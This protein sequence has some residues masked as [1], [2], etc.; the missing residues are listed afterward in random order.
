MAARAL[1]R[2]RGEVYW[3]GTFCDFGFELLTEDTM[4]TD[5]KACKELPWRLK[6]SRDGGGSLFQ[7]PNGE[8]ERWIDREKAGVLGR[9]NAYSETQRSWSP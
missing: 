4:V 5:P 2:E 3:V 8:E 1:L 9:Q 7:S 6:I